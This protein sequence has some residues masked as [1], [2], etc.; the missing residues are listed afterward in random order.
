MQLEF[1]FEKDRQL[2]IPFP[3]TPSTNQDTLENLKTELNSWTLSESER[4]DIEAAILT[5]K[6]RSISLDPYAK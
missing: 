4:R 5:E 2:G 1:N 6:E 3:S